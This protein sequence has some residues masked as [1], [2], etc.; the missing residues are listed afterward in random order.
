MSNNKT[1]MKTL[2]KLSENSVANSHFWRF[3]C[4]CVCVQCICV[5]SRHAADSLMA[6]ALFAAWQRTCLF[7]WNFNTLLR[8]GRG[9]MEDLLIV[10]PLSALCIKGSGAIT[11]NLRSEVCNKSTRRAFLN[12]GWIFNRWLMKIRIRKM[13]IFFISTTFV[14][15]WFGYCKN[16]WYSG[17]ASTANN[18][19]QITGTEIKDKEQQSL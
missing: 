17:A 6:F 12:V 11:F 14:W 13:F 15:N 16:Q 7:L 5:S 18:Q 9:C 8:Q 2:T 19:L 4:M 10:I 1:I 3:V